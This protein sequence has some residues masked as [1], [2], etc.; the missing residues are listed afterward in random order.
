LLC[1][2]CYDRSRY[3]SKRR[4]REPR[5][6]PKVIHGKGVTVEATPVSADALDE[7]PPEAA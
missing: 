3:G 4:A 2:G 1:D 5:W 7:P 6:E